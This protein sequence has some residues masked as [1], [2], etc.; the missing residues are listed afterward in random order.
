M[1]RSLQASTRKKR[2]KESGF[3]LVELSMTMLI[4]AVAMTVGLKLFQMVRHARVT[5]TISQ[6]QNY[7]SAIDSFRDQYGFIPGDMP[8]A[9][10]MLPD[11]NAANF[12]LNGNGNRQVGLASGANGALTTGVVSQSE[13]V[14]FWKHL[15]LAGYPAGVEVNADWQAPAW[16][17]THPVAP[18]SGGF[19]F[20]YTNDIR[21]D[22]SND[23]THVLRITN[24]GILGNTSS[25]ETNGTAAI[26][27]NE[28]AI[29]ETKI[30][31][32]DPNT[33]RV[34]LRSFG[35]HG[36]HTRPDASPGMDAQITRRSC[37]IFF[38][39]NG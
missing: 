8:A 1:I 34:R 37:T 24:M 11:C 17:R 18:L 12:C 4:I 32:G 33:G 19:E 9:Q 27:P 20:F 3:T 14:Q 6:V 10:V 13:T 25:T 26:S 30:D 5:S 15:G 28:A 31:N 36:C 29:I 7:E 23:P 22:V 38:L 21:A 16:G 35:D 2:R 39:V